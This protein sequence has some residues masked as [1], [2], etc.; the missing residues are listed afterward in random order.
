MIQ[1]KP[2]PLELDF[3]GMYD[4]LEWNNRS[5]FCFLAVGGESTVSAN[6]YPNASNGQLKVRGYY[7]QFPGKKSLK[8]C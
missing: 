4:L 8:A 1:N 7:T 3:S 5:F 2:R 6:L